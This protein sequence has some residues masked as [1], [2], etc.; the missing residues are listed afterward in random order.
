MDIQIDHGILLFLVF[1][2]VRTH[3]HQQFIFN[4]STH[5][6]RTFATNCPLTLT[7]TLPSKT[8]ID[9]KN[10]HCPQK[11]TFT[12]TLPSKTHI[13]LKHIHCHQTRHQFTDYRIQ[14][15]SFYYQVQVAC[16]I[17]H[18]F[19]LHHAKVSVIACKIC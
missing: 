1:I 11:H 8:Y 13:A 16:V 19:S 3:T 2:C 17:I 18:K 6:C 5:N 7:R 10:V 4:N 12:R 15:P 9:I 14:S